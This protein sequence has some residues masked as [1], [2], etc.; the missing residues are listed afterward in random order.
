MTTE[1][2]SK[3][4]TAMPQFQS[5]PAMIEAMQKNSILFWQRQAEILGAMKGPAG[6]WFERRFAGSQAALAACEAMCR[7]QTP[8]EWFDEQQKWALG[9]YQRVLADIAACQQ[10]CGRIIEGIGPSL[11][12]TA[13][14]PH[15]DVAPQPEVSA[16]RRHARH[17]A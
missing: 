17:K 6:G 10:E 9:A 15:G 11:V 14:E 16:P 2:L 7:A 12:P 8:A 13:D 1:E 4:W 5:P 3:L